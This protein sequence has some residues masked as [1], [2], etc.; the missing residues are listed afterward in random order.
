MEC[1]MHLRLLAT[2]IFT[3]SSF[4]LASSYIHYFDFIVGLMTKESLCKK[5]PRKKAFRKYIHYKVRDEITYVY[6]NGCTIEV[7]NV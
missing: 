6:D 5:F 3:S 2:L 1:D 7:W 4:F